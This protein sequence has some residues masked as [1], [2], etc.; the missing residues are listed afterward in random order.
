VRK[1]HTASLA[2]G[3]GSNG[4]RDHVERAV[5]SPIPQKLLNGEVH[6]W[7]R[8]VHG[9]PDHLV[10]GLISEFE[11]SGR[12]IVLD[13]FCGSGTTLVECMKRGIRAI[14]VDAN[15]SSE[16]AA[17]VKTDWSID[18][19]RL[20]GHLSC[21]T[22]RYKTLVR[23]NTVF[24]DDTFVYLW[25][26]GMLDRGWISE[27]PLKKVLALKK[28]IGELRA[29]PRYRSFL[30]LALVSEAVRGAANIKYG[31]ELYCVEPKDNADVLDGFRDRVHV[32]INDLKKVSAIPTRASE[33]IAGDS[34]HCGRL[35][36]SKWRKR[37]DAVI[38]SPPYPTEHDYTRNSRLELALLG[39]VVDIAS[40]RKIK[41]GMIRSHTK[42]IYKEDLDR[43]LVGRIPRIQKLVAKVERRAEEKDHGFAKLYGTVVQEYFGGMRSH[44]RSI[45]KL[46]KAGAQCAYVVGDQ[47]SYLRV[48]VPTAELLSKIAAL[49]GFKTIEI[50]K[51]RG[52][53]ASTTKAELEEHVLILRFSD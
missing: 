39:D 13:P 50:R 36:G 4:T 26:S 3:H 35:L 15:P 34:R 47:S 48:H 49:E 46:L 30:M 2:L 5:G 52:R 31:P 9:F 23:S 16:F 53:F 11:L 20:K 6:D 41:K 7:F 37:I 45:K 44:F 25:S 1:Q 22:E 18:A 10:S 17:R 19:D 42:G 28:S 51:W 21:V 32:M 43:K 12:S 27:K 33:I 29:G 38:C 14:G 40:L 8:I 24:D